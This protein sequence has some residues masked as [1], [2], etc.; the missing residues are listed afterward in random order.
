[1]RS[2]PFIPFSLARSVEVAPQEREW[3]HEHKLDGYRIEAVL[4]DGAVQLFTRNAHD[5]SAKFSRVA[6]ELATLPV[7]SAT[8]DGEIV[9]VDSRGTASFQRL[10]QR[11]DAGST[12]G[13]RYHVFDLLAVDGM[14]LRRQP[15]RVRRQALRALLRY[16]PRASVIR[17]TPT[18][19]LTGGDPLQ[20]ARARGLEGVICK[21]L[22]A[23]YVSGR[24]GGWL[25]VKAGRRQE[26]VVIGFTDPD[27]TREGFGAL[28]LG[29]YD[30]A[31]VLHY[32]GKVGTGFD[33]ST[34]HDLRRRLDAL[35]TRTRPIAPRNGI[36]ASSTH[37]VKP[38]LVVEVAFA[39]WTDDQL[40]RQPVFK[41]VREDKD[42]TQ[43]RRE[44]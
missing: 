27:G 30:S 37:W 33:R 41:G 19:A 42:A 39:E 12:V 38:V 43:I 21:R 32:S 23:P 2:A 29:V 40:L 18:F 6:S 36:P 11:I 8:L 4:R 28:L 7:T 22:D 31:G 17:A 20:Q 24:N 13:V 3:L 15:L 10:Q 14:D 35:Q 44:P 9:A 26:M 5:W 25:K 16:K 1:V 34:L